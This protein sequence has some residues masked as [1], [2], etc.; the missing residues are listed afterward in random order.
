MLRTSSSRGSPSVPR[1]LAALSASKELARIAASRNAPPR[2]RCRTG[3][4]STLYPSAYDGVRSSLAAAPATESRS[5]RT[6]CE[7]ATVSDG[8]DPTRR[9]LGAAYLLANRPALAAQEFLQTLIEN[10][11]D[12]YAYWGLSEASRMRGDTRGATAAIS[13]FEGVFIGPRGGVTAGEIRPCVSE[14]RRWSNSQGRCRRPTAA[15]SLA[16]SMRRSRL[17]HL[18]MPTTSSSSVAAMRPRPSQLLGEPAGGGCPA[19]SH[20]IACY[21]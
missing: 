5:A 2:N 1:A 13:L 4:S 9:T 12:A 10:P 20:N 14:H 8:S 7:P 15:H 6:L 19:L 3:I 11:N 17:C 21:L 18:L 16:C